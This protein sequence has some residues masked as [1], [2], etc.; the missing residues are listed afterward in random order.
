MDFLK[1]LPIGLRKGTGTRE[2]ILSLMLRSERY[3]VNSESE[4]KLVFVHLF[5]RLQKFFDKTP[6]YSN[7]TI[8]SITYWNNKG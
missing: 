2:V 4:A 3:L 1:L 5:C 6:L 7:I 8:I